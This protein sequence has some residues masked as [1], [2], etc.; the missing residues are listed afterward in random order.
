MT[1]PVPKGGTIGNN[2]RVWQHGGASQNPTNGVMT[3]NVE[4]YT[5]RGS[6]VVAANQF[7]VVQA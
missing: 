6:R 3:D 4:T 2:I 5:L 7:L 1:Q